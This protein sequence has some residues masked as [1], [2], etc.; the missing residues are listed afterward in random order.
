MGKQ[1][2]DGSASTWKDLKESTP[3]DCN[4]K[5]S[6]LWLSVAN[7][8]TNEFNS[9]LYINETPFDNKELVAR[10]PYYLEK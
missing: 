3:S 8:E 7:L 1:P 2:V 4:E 10:L 9:K 6:R 5:I